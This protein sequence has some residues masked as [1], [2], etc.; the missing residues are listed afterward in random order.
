MNVP[1]L[2]QVLSGQMVLSEKNHLANRYQLN[3]M[4]EHIPDTLAIQDRQIQNLVSIRLHHRLANQSNY[5]EERFL[6]E[7]KGCDF[8]IEKI[9]NTYFLGVIQEQVLLAS[10][11]IGELLPE[12]LF[13]WRKKSCSFHSTIVVKRSILI[14]QYRGNLRSK[15]GPRHSFSTFFHLFPLQHSSN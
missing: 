10:Y 11:N 13:L 9:K 3:D 15:L 14:R 1:D 8:S 4:S 12:H 7:S 6:K 2:L 5:W